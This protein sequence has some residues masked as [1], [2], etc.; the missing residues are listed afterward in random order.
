[1]IS[2]VTREYFPAMVGF[3]RLDPSQGARRDEPQS[4]AAN[5]FW[6][7]VTHPSMPS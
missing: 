7:S 3:S 5:R 2:A 1:V 6:A 4:I